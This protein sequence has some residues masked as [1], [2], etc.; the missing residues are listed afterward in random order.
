LSD[1]SKSRPESKVSQAV[2]LLLAMIVGILMTVPFYV[3]V[4]N[5]Q[6]G[7]VPL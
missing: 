1:S 4:L 3:F 5:S 7:R 6:F 2:Q